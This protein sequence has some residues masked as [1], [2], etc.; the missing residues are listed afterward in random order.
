MLADILANPVKRWMLVV[1]IVIT[2]ASEIGLIVMWK[3]AVREAK[4]HEG[5]LQRDCAAEDDCKR[6]TTQENLRMQQ[7]MSHAHGRHDTC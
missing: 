7:E 3:K 4:E 6:R 5:I 1:L 2:V